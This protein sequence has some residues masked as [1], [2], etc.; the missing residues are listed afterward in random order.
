MAGLMASARP[1]RVKTCR[2]FSPVNRSR[3]IVCAP[4]EPIATEK[5]INIL[6]LSNIENFVEKSA[7]REARIYSVNAMRT[8]YLRPRESHRNPQTIIPTAKAIK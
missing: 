6:A 5:A 4:I 7:M 3:M 2:S 1:T 8:V